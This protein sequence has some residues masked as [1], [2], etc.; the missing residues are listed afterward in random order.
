MGL[1]PVG[2]VE[3]MVQ[4]S[5]LVK[6][7]RG[8]VFSPRQRQQ[9]SF[10]IQAWKHLQPRHIVALASQPVSCVA[11]ELSVAAP[12]RGPMAVPCGY[13]VLKARQPKDTASSPSQLIHSI[14]PY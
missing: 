12:Q 14:I 9:A 3:K 10:C 2:W 8:F 7:V 5:P 11:E 4:M 1:E 13:L 6:R